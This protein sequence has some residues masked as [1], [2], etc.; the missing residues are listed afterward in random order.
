MSEKRKRR[1]V[2]VRAGDGKTIPGKPFGIR[3]ITAETFVELP[4]CAM[5]RRG[6]ACGDFVAAPGEATPTPAPD[7]PTENEE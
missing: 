3:V 6:L 1:T 2:R 7:A 4:W 5:V